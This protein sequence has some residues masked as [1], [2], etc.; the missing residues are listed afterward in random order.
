MR[1][2]ARYSLADHRRNEDILE[3]LKGGPVKKKLR[4]YKRKS[5][6]QDGRH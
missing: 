3:K 6:Q 2:T 1:G 4:Q 5:S